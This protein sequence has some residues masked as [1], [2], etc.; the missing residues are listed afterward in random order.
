M[1]LAG[2]ILREIALALRG[3]QNGLTFAVLSQL[4]GYEQKL[5]ERALYCL[6]DVGHAKEEGNQRWHYRP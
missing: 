1:K 2:Y 3:A 6:G 4:T 5:I